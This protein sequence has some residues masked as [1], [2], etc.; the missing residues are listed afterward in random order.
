M[1]L[2]KQQHNE[3]KNFLI[4]KIRDKLKEYNPET[5]SISFPFIRKR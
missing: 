4:S 1:A 5:S 2:S 3:I